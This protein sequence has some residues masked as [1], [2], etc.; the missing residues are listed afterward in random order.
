MTFRMFFGWVKTAM[1]ALIALAGAAIVALDAVM[2]SGAVPAFETSN[3]TVAAVSMVAAVLIFLFA[4]LLLTCSFYKLGDDGIFSLMGVFA[5]RVAYNDVSRIAVNAVTSEVFI[6]W[7]KDGAGAETV[8]RLN[9]MQKDSKAM[10]A[11]LERR[12][13]FATIDTFTPPEKKKKKG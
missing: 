5:D 7:R 12:C 2:I 8:T 1:L 10:L 3:V 6:S 9:L 11:E 4:V 13:A